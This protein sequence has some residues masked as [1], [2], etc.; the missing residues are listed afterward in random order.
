MKKSTDELLK[1]MQTS[2][3]VDKFFKDNPDDIVFNGLEELFDYHIK[4][5]G[6]KKREVYSGASIE[7]TF[8]YQII[9]G[10]RGATRDKIIQICFG[11][12]LDLPE[13]QRFIKVS[14]NRELYVRDPRDVIIIFALK[15]K[16]SLIETNLELENRGFS[17]LD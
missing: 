3:D 11:L 17:I 5:K 8:G 1:E 10:T 6:L 7:R 13:A 4:T 15:E 2:K 12:K 9:H 16:K 14:G